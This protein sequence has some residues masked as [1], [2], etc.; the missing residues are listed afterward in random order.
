MTK[1]TLNSRDGVFPVSPEMCSNTD[2]RD[3]ST[4]EE[5]KIILTKISINIS[6]PNPDTI[7]PSYL[8]SGQRLD[9]FQVCSLHFFYILL[10]SCH[11]ALPLPPSTDKTNPVNLPQPLDGNI[12][13]T[14]CFFL[15]VCLLSIGR[16]DPISSSLD[17]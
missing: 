10:Q 7:L 12:F 3:V 17:S 16:L 15:V 5:T 9:L 4:G 14:H 2:G 1:R 13:N 8:L 11:G 6:N